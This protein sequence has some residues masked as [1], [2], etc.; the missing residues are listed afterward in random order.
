MRSE[1]VYILEYSYYKYGDN[2]GN[3]RHWNDIEY[4]NNNTDAKAIT[5][6][7]TGILYHIIQF[8]I[9]IRF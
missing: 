3:I 6:E 5:E 2:R 1:N 9:K 8:S 4:N 7:L